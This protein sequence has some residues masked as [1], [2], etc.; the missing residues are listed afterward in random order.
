[1]KKFLASIPNRLKAI[2]L[3]WFLVNLIF[4]FT[5]KAPFCHDNDFYPFEGFYTW[6]YDYSEFI[7]Y[8]IAPIVIYFLI[9][10][11]KKKGGQRGVNCTV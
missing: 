5:T 1:M 9:Y 4:L 11:W 3:V 7:F 10:L 2:Y 8:L 6:D